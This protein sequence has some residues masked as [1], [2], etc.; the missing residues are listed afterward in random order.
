MALQ[1]PLAARNTSIVHASFLFCKVGSVLAECE[2]EE[3]VIEGMKV[4]LGDR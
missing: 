2:K 3:V 1:L 4:G